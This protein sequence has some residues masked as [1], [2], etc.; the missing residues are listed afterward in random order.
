MRRL[1]VIALAGA[2]LLVGACGAED[3]PSVATTPP[4]S[5]ITDEAVVPSSEPSDHA[6]TDDPTVDS[7]AAASAPTPLP[8]MSD[9]APSERDDAGGESI[10]VAVEVTIVITDPDDG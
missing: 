9:A 6:T 1:T 10:G 3:V 8:D 2:A 4:P 5:T 7:D